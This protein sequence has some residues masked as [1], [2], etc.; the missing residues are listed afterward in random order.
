L[1][2]RGL[3]APEGEAYARQAYEAPEGD[4]ERLLAGLWV[5]LL[6]VERV[7]RHD[8]FF[9]LGGHS[10]LAVRLINRVQQT[11]SVKLPLTALFIAPS[12]AGVAG[13]VKEHLAGSGP[14]HLPAIVRV[15]RS[16]MLSPSYAQERL[17]FLSQL[18]GGSAAYH[19]PV[20]LHLRG[21]LDRAALCR[22]LDGVW[23][24][25]ESLRSVFVTKDGKAHVGLLGADQGLW[26]LEH[27]LRNE[28]DAA[29]SL[30]MLSR[31]E[32]AAAFDLERG[33]LVRARLIQMADAEHVLLVTQHHIVSDGWSMGILLKEVGALY[34]AFIR[35]EECR[36]D[37]LTVQY[38]DYASWQRQWLSGER[39]ARQAAYWR[40]ALQDAPVMLNLPTDRPRP[41][42]Q[43]FA[44]SSVPV[45]LDAELTREVKRLSLRYGATPFMV[46]LAAWAVVL[47]RL[48][49]QDDIVIGTPTANRGRREVEGLIGFFVNTLALR[50]DL[51]GELDVAGLLERVR[52]VALGAQDHQDLPFEQVVEIVQPP[53][54]LE[55]TPVFQVLLTW[56]TLEEDRLGL[57]GLVSEPVGVAYEM[58][59]FDL[60]LELAE[61]GSELVGSLG[62]ATA[63]FDR[64][65]IERHIGYLEVVL[66]GL[67]AEAVGPVGRLNL[68]PSDE[69]LQL[70]EGWNAT[71][72][73]Y[74]S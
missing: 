71:V 33:P 51:S 62:Y 49:G 2:R 57:P 74:G 16:G 5:E 35:G 64:E 63:L 58:S 18:E 30:A 17:W 73:D 65:T 27:D 56:Q 44:G 60:E 24:R 50:V 12:L 21:E 45:Q 46:V 29:A 54:R 10:L 23:A 7:G 66:R 43:S 68:L 19:V 69:R 6:G 61:V 3:P 26:L 20:A 22:A 8:S 40:E 39:Q 42:Q 13:A 70:V 25:H 31:E 11:F 55:H 67:V 28:P 47:S 59:K 37:E 15:E 1:D 41:A 53:R 4:V 9:E 32:F 34:A 52:S 36:L 48:S 72:H 38:P 14:D